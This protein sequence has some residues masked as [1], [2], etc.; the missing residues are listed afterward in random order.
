MSDYI[1]GG[2]TQQLSD[3]PNPLFAYTMYGMITNLTELTSGTPTSPGWSPANQPPPNAKGKVLWTYGG[4]GAVPDNMPAS[5]E[6]INNILTATNNQGWD[7]VDFDDESNMN[8]DNIINTMKDLKQGQSASYTFLAGWDYN[9]PEQSQL[10]QEINDKV[11]TI[12]KAHTC[13]RF[14][15]MCYAGAMWDMPTIQA[16]VPNA[17][18][19]TIEHV[20]NSKEVILA[21]TPAGLTDENLDYFLQ[22]VTSKKLG[23]LFIWDYPNLNSTYLDTIVNTLGIN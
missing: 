6:D 5:S 4:A 12:A 1:I 17:V 10:G 7:G 14:V 8:V 21:L 9:N 19:R 2:W 16:N 15:L 3:S 11:A 13:D 20:G 23:G 22:Q 18:D